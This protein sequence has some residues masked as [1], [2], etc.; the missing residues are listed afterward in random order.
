MLQPVRDRRR[1]SGGLQELLKATTA[2]VLL[3]AAACPASSC[4]FPPSRLEVGPRDEGGVVRLSE[5]SFGLLVYPCFDG[6][7]TRVELVVASHPPGDDH[8]VIVDEFDPPVDPRTLVVSTDPDSQPIGS[9]RQVIDRAALERLNHDPSYMTDRAPLAPRYL[10][11]NVTADDG[12]SVG[13]G[14]T[15][16]LKGRFD[17]RVGEAGVGARDA[18][19]DDFRCWNDRSRPAWES[20][21]G[22]G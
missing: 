10:A 8:V 4:V 19:L 21:D 14:A 18:A 2:F 1:S 12:G 5:D 16:P 6:L 9:R 13:D 11:V 20:V 15:L 3:A 17:L 22:E 7:V